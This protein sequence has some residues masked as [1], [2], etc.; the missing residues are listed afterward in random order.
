M[1]KGLPESFWI[2]PNS[3]KSEYDITF[4]VL[5]LI[6]ILLVII[7]YATFCMRLAS[8]ANI[9]LN[10]ERGMAARNNFL[11]VVELARIELTDCK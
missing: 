10:E 11:I 1:A 4:Q 6:W 2:A 8:K 3:P 7:L 9:H 5:W